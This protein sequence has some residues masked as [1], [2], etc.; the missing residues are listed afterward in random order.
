MKHI[1]I[2]TAVAVIMALTGYLSFLQTHYQE[3]LV[4]ETLPV[5][6]IPTYKEAPFIIEGTE[7][8]LVNG[9]SEVAQPDSV[10]PI[11]TTYFGNEVEADLNGDGRLDMVFL[12][13]QNTGGSGTLFYAVAALNTGAG[14]VGSQ[15]FF[16]GDRIAPQTTE[17]SQNPNHKNVIV[18]NYMEREAGQ[19]MSESP[20]VGTSVWLKLDPTTMSLGTVEQNFPGEA[21]VNTMTLS[22]KPWTWIATTYNDGEVVTPVQTSAFTL[23]FDE[24]GTV[25]IATDCNAMGSTYTVVDNQITFEDMMATEMFCEGSQEQD[26]AKMLNEVQSYFFTGKGEL[27]FDLKLDSGSTVFR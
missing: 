10:A 3:D 13:T 7:V 25:S 18:V 11:M 9:V 1:I 6:A 15:G 2:L 23:T 8:R 14:W 12:V 19:P 20:S 21:D 26:F 27:V 4:I 17:L 24:N 22:M 5:I 16:L